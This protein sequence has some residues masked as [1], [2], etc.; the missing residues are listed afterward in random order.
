MSYSP[1]GADRYPDYEFQDYEHDDVE[2]IGESKT[3]PYYYT[4]PD[5]KVFGA[6]VNEEDERL[7]PDPETERTLDA[8]EELGEVLE[9]IGEKTGWESLSEWAREHLEDE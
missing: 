1:T 5:D 9:E 6:K 2:Y 3:M 8:E 4:E 7:E